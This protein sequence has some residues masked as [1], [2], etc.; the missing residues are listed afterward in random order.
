MMASKFLYDE[1]EDDEVLNS[2]WA[3]SAGLHVDE[4]N[5]LEREFLQAIVSHYHTSLIKAIC[6]GQNK[7]EHNEHILKTVLTDD[8]K[9]T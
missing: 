6:F 5:T 3:A 2:E 9:S 1:G 8:S 4:I 7:F